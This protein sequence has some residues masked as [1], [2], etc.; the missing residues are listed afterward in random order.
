MSAAGY[1]Y[2]IA[3]SLHGSTPHLGYPGLSTIEEARERLEIDRA[4]AANAPGIEIWIIDAYGKRV[5]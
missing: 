2:A 5:D 4:D 1:P 3:N